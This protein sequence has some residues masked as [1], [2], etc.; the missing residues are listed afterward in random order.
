MPNESNQM[1]ISDLYLVVFYDRCE[2][3]RNY[4]EWYTQS[5]FRPSRVLD[6]SISVIKEKETFL[7]LSRP[8]KSKVR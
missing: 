6:R 2:K 7:F 5:V 8:S 4:I 3:R 1:L